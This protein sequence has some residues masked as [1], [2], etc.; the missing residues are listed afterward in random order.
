MNH[1]VNLKIWN[2]PP[3]GENGYTYRVI[4]FKKEEKKKEISLFGYMI[5]EWCRNSIVRNCVIA[6]DYYYIIHSEHLTT[7]L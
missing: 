7:F 2:L 4:K 3:I 5:L 1:R 6:F